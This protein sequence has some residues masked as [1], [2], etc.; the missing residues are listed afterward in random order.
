[1]QCRVV[2]RCR[3]AD[4]PEPA[5]IGQRGDP[6]A[7]IAAELPVRG[8]ERGAVQ[9]E[10]LELESLAVEVERCAGRGGRVAT[11][12]E[13]GDDPRTFGEQVELEIDR[14]DPPGWRGIVET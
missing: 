2:D 13:R 10:V 4:D 3:P 1:R 7:A 14:I 6:Q 5:R 8:I 9:P 12:L 11:Q